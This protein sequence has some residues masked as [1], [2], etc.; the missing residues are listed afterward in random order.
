[1][2]IFTVIKKFITVLPICTSIISISGA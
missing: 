2:N 1:V